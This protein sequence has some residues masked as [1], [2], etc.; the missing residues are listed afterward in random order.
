MSCAK[1]RQDNRKLE[2]KRNVDVTAEERCRR[3]LQSIQLRNSKREDRL[4]KRRN[5]SSSHAPL[6]SRG[7]NRSSER[8]RF[9]L[10]RL[11]KKVHE[12]E[13]LV[14]GVNGKDRAR[15]LEA[16]TQFRKLLSIGRTLTNPMS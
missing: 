16:T 9:S 3:H 7:F 15:Q 6:Q 11:T 1:V 4:K 2:F 5:V 10:A 14:V 12:V 8:V 13:K